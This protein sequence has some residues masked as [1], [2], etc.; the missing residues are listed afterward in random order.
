M[1]HPIQLVG[2]YIFPT[3]LVLEEKIG[4][5][6]LGQEYVEIVI[7]HLDSSQ[8]KEVGPPVGRALGEK[9]PIAL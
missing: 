9:C 3:L 2:S 4:P 5:G 1:G 7:I 6:D 8:R